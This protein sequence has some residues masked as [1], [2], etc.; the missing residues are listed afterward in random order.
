MRV[1]SYEFKGTVPGA[2]L[3]AHCGSFWLP[4][5]AEQSKPEKSAPNCGLKPHSVLNSRFRPLNSERFLILSAPYNGRHWHGWPDTGVLGPELP[6][7]CTPAFPTQ[8]EAPEVAAGSTC[9]TPGL[10]PLAHGLALLGMKEASPHCLC[11]PRTPAGGRGPGWG[12]VVA[13]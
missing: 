4:P 10:R 9:P 7:P 12:A 1:S 5:A 11:A 6:S 2:A 13:S 8:M 3:S